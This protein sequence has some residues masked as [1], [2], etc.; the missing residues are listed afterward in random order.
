MWKIFQRERTLTGM[1]EIRAADLAV[2]LK[3]LCSKLMILDLRR[4]DELERYPY[5]IPGAPP[6]AGID[7]PG[8]IGWLPRDLGRALRNR[9]Y[10]EKLLSSSSVA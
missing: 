9:P 5:I 6:T 8:L 4:R 2:L 7:L 10:S 1:M 3:P